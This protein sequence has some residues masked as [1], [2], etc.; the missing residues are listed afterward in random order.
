MTGGSAEM[1]GVL[2]V[3]KPAGPTSHDVVAMARRALRTR[4]IGH[5]GTLD[6]FATGLLLL[7]IGSATRIA[8]HLTGSDK[9]YR[10]TIRLGAATDTDDHTGSVLEERDANGI[11]RADVE[12]ALEAQRGTIMQMPPQYSAKKK[13][14]QR[15]YSVARSGGVAELEAVGITIRELRL[16]SWNAPFAEIDV[17]CSAGTYIRAIA[18]DLGNVLE[19][20]GHLTALRRTEIGAISIDDALPLDAM[21]DPE[22]V[23]AALIAPLRALGDMATLELNDEEIGHIRHGR[24]IPVREGVIGSIALSAYGELFALAVADADSIRPR[25]VFL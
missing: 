8:A 7:C 5:T 14:G 20:G 25:K 19:V 1:S 3:D 10:A 9:R 22:R 21:S 15:A 24:S 6:P 18:R 12:N 13:D 23:T 11:T 2:A 4:R 16:V 17:L